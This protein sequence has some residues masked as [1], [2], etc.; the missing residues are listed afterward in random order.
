MNV[1]PTATPT[2]E[3]TAGWNNVNAVND[4]KPRA[5][6]AAP[7]ADLWGTWSGVDPATRW[8]QYDLADARAGR[9]GIEV[10]FWRDQNDAT[11]A[12]RRERAEVVEGAVLER[13]HVD[14]RHRRRPATASLRDEP[15]TTDFDA[16]TT[17]RAAA[18]PERDG[19]AAPSYAAV[20]VSEWRSSPTRRSRI[21]PI[22]VRTGV[23][24]DP[25]PAGDASTRPSPTA[26]ARPTSPCRGPRSPPSRSPARAASPSSGIVPGS[27]VPAAATVWVRATAPGPDELGRRRSPCSTAAGVAPEPA[28]R[29]SACSTTTA[30]AR[31]SPVEW[32]AVDPADYA[33]D[34][35]FT[36]AG[37]VQ[38]R[39]AGRQGRD[40]DRDRRRRRRGPRHAGA[41]RV[42]I[43][44][45]PAGP[46]SGWHTGAVTVSVPR[47]PTTATR[48]RPSR[49]RVDGGGG[50]RTPRRSP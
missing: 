10:D 45:A 16:V 20:G 47:R 24:V 9:P 35:E 13:H 23:G 1:A 27:P 4:G 50:W 43:T 19:P 48:R 39:S 38:T 17:T 37:T 22:D 25:D 2:A 40:G 30:P 34:G 49:S 29:R 28:G 14:R 3:Y 6:P 44:S 36:V 12:A 31:T 26:A 7:R 46:G 32:E 42:S 21:E 33:T 15:N 41:G 11:P 5:T 8:L 18:R